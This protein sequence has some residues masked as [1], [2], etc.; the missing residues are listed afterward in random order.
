MEK[1]YRLAFLCFLAFLMLGGV[2]PVTGV[3]GNVASDPGP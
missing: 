1:L 3:G 2:F